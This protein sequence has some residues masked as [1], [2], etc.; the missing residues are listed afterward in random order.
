MKKMT[1]ASIAFAAL[2]LIA[3]I[4]FA[5]DEQSQQV[6]GGHDPNA[7]AASIGSGSGSGGSERPERINPGSVL[8]PGHGGQ[9]GGDSGQR[10]ATGF[11]GV[12]GDIVFALYNVTVTR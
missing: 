4:T 7:P 10:A 9:G 2:T 12:L 1:S 8:D 5:A 3:S 11:I 6:P